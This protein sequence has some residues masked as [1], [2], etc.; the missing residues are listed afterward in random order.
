MNGKHVT[1]VIV[2]DPINKLSMDL[3]YNIESKRCYEVNQWV[4]F[5]LS[6]RFFY[7][8]FYPNPFPLDILIKPPF[9]K[10]ELWP[11]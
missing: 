9:Q 6:K 2:D 7:D 11:L 4:K 3:F 5:N 1:H 10:G 8:Y